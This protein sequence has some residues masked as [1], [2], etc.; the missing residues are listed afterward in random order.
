MSSSSRKR[1]S[2]RV[3]TR[4]VTRREL[5]LDTA[6][7]LLGE[8][9]PDEISL[10]DIS[11]RA[12][13]AVGSAY[14][15]F[16]NANAIFAALAARFAVELDL[17]LA[18]AYTEDEAEDWQSIVETAV[19]RTTQL[20]NER[21]DYR[22]L[23][24]GGK[25]PAEIKLL[26]REN[27]EAVGQIIIDAISQQFVIPEFPRRVEIFFI[28]VEIADLVFML[29][30]MRHGEIT[31]TMREEAQTA[32]VSYLRAYLPTH[33]PRKPA[34]NPLQDDSEITKVRE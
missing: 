14:H 17:R 28:A 8:R 2:E 23:I 20:Y 15:H 30:Q 24:L 7:E 9:A 33:L 13:I 16:A 25:A 32:M 3:Q 11:N 26:D 5:L 29:S 1:G 10:S 6:V 19:L 34:T 27:D 21:P 4:S 18:E 12:E 22:Q 31:P